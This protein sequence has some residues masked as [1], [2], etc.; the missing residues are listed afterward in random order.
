MVPDPHDLESKLL[1][2]FENASHEHGLTIVAYCL[3]GE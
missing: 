1:E 3:A 2:Q